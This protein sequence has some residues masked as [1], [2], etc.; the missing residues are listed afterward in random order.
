LS[1][2]SVEYSHSHFHKRV[3]KMNKASDGNGESS[4]AVL[5]EHLEAMVQAN[6]GKP[7]RD[8]TIKQIFEH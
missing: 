4:E 3:G 1:G 8:V 2:F 7:I 5:R 6:K